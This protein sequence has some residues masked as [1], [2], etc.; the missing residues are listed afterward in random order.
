MHKPGQLEGGQEGKAGVGNGEVLEMAPN[1]VEGVRGLQNT[2][3]FTSFYESLIP[4][5]RDYDSCLPLRFHATQPRSQAYAEPC[6]KL[7]KWR[8]GLEER[9]NF[10]RLGTQQNASRSIVVMSLEDRSRTTSNWIYGAHR[11]NSTK[12]SKQ[13]RMANQD[14]TQKMQLIPGYS[15]TFT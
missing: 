12:K 6:S 1:S 8:R 13:Y 9:S 11:N 4:R 7:T 15:A 5:L 14:S 3:L 2:S 10:W